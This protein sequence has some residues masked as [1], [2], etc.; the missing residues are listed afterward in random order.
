MI[1][2]AQGLEERVQLA[3]KGTKMCKRKWRVVEDKFGLI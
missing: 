1:A 3:R 2:L